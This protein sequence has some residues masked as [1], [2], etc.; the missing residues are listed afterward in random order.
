MNRANSKMITQYHLTSQNHVGA[1]QCLVRFINDEFER[2]S[3]LSQFEKQRR[4]DAISNNHFTEY[5]N[6]K[7]KLCKVNYDFAN[8]SPILSL[9]T[10]VKLAIIFNLRLIF[11]L[12]SKLLLVDTVFVYQINR[13]FEAEMANICNNYFQYESS[14]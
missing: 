6:Y 2:L 7:K 10:Y 4:I 1:V 5:H 11:N 8:F 12:I 3:G 14:R 9:K 13:L